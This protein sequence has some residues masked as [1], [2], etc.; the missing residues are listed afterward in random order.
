[1][2]TGHPIAN[3][4]KYGGDLALSCSKDPVPEPQDYTRVSWCSECTSGRRD[5]S[6]VTTEDLRATC[7]W[8][9][10]L[11]YSNPDP[12]HGWTFEAP[13]PSWSQIV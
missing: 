12:K 8:L 11:R 5:T 10:A 13:P 3:D 4:Y 2:I 6:H 7:I 1:M 9:H